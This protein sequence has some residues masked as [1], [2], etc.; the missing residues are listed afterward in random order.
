MGENAV[1]MK[2]N[3]WIAPLGPDSEF[4]SLLLSD[5]MKSDWDEND[6]NEW[7]LTKTTTFYKNIKLQGLFSCFVNILHEDRFISFFVIEFN[8]ILDYTLTLF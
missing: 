3:L 1:K 4:I 5:E 7:K 8:L 6:H 2:W